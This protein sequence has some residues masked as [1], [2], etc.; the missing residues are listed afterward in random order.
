MFFCSGDKNPDKPGPVCHS[1]VRLVFDDFACFVRFSCA[2]LNRCSL[3]NYIPLVPPFR[4]IDLVTGP[5]HRVFV[6]R[7]A[8]SITGKTNAK[9]DA[10]RKSL[11][12]LAF[13]LPNKKEEDSQKREIN[14]NKWTKPSGNHRF[15]TRVFRLP[16]PIAILCAL[17]LF[18]SFSFSLFHPRFS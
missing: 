8:N 13:S 18:L 1:R 6:L 11:V 16:A 15:Q 9:T 14:R 17:F 3:F 5:V 4:Y 10:T 2:T 12:L 7:L